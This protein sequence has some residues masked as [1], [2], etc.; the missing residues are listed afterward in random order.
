[1]VG[2]KFIYEVGKRDRKKGRALLFEIVERASSIALQ[3]R[4]DIGVVIPEIT[5][6]LI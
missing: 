6:A 2:R 3:R 4:R 5:I 1:M